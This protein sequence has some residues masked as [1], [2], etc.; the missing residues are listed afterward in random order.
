MQTQNE[1]V[2]A[3]FEHV[4][5]CYRKPE[6]PFYDEVSLFETLH[7]EQL[8][9]G[10]LSDQK[11][12][13]K[14][15]RTEHF[16]YVKTIEVHLLLLLGRLQLLPIL[17]SLFSLASDVR[18]AVHLLPA[19]I[20]RWWN[21]GRELLILGLVCLVHRRFLQLLIVL[22]RRWLLLLLLLRR[23]LRTLSLIVRRFAR[24]CFIAISLLSVCSAIL[25]S[26]IGL[27]VAFGIRIRLFALLTGSRNGGF[28][29]LAFSLVHDFEH[30]RAHRVGS[31]VVQ[32]AIPQFPLLLDESSV[33][34]CL[35]DVLHPLLR[36]IRSSTS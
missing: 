8:L 18:G 31:V 32:M 3:H 10:F 30:V 17:T 36:S 25:L 15:T 4:G 29:R 35:V 2:A 23:F 7:R 13:A 11:D 9:I 19:F 5:L 33:D 12:L 24:S 22:Q 14:R 28:A 6:L 34:R 21:L 20:G 16:D 26:A 1:W 27:L